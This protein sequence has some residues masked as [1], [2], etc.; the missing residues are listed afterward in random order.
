MGWKKWPS[1]LKG[2][3]IG[4]IIS[5]ILVI[6]AL[7]TPV[8]NIFALFSVLIIFMTN[9]LIKC[10]FSFESY[11]CQIPFTWG[12]FVFLLEFFFLGAIIGWICRTGKR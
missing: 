7:L 5:V 10:E 4:L 6:L 8:V 1:W 12:I 3:V 9:W 2:G 11:Y